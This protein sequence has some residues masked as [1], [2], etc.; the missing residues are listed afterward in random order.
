MSSLTAATKRESKA[1]ER[2]Y[3]LTLNTKWATDLK[4]AEVRK[5]I[6]KFLAD[7]G[8]KHYPA[9]GAGPDLLLENGGAIETKGKNFDVKRALE[10]IIRYT[11]T[12]PRFG[13]AV[14]TDSLD[15]RTL[16]ALDVIE[17]SLK[18]MGKPS[19]EV[20]LVAKIEETKYRVRVYA[21]SIDLFDYASSQLVGKLQT[22]LNIDLAQRIQ[23][24]VEIM[25]S[26]DEQLRIILEEDAKSIM[27]YEVT[28]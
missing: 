28:L 20:Y 25:C 11:L 1:S 18:A 9:K 3:V 24:N 21:S 12:H 19:M 8:M 5:V 17:K 27:G 4:E 15:I 2:L 6:Q 14:S 13:I 23:R 10:Q 7:Q 16:F 22:P 26:L